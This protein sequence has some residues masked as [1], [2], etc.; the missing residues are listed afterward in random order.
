MGGNAEHIKLRDSP[1]ELQKKL[2]LSSQRF[3]NF[4]NFARKTHNEYLSSNP[5]SQWADERVVWT[6]LPEQE[7]EGI[8]DIMCCLCQGGKLFDSTYPE[9]R[10]RQGARAR[11]HQVRRTWQQGKRESR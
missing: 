2:G 9:E 10:I 4:K 6:A 1:A 11:L 5:K 7:I 8:I 3:E